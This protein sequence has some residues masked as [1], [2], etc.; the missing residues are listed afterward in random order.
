MGVFGD[1]LNINNFGVGISLALV[2][3]TATSLSLNG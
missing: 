3:L 1:I 2:A